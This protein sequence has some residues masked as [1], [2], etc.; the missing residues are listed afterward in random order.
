MAGL[1]A[2]VG[3]AQDLPP[4]AYM[5]TPSGSNAMI[6]SYSLFNGS[7]FTDP[8]LPIQDFKAR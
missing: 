8:T 4:R 5:I 3:H 7:V 6:L 2:V 1:V